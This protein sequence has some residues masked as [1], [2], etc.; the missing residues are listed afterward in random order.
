MTSYPTSIIQYP[1]FAP[2]V[3]LQ[4]D[5][6]NYNCIYPNWGVNCNQT[7]TQ[8]SAGTCGEQ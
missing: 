4:G 6:P 3:D 7:A 2:T 8:C 5:I 1:T